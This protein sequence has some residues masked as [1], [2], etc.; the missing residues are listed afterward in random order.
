MSWTL[1]FTS[2]LFLKRNTK[3]LDVHVDLCLDFVDTRLAVQALSLDLLSFVLSS[4]QLVQMDMSNS[5]IP[6]PALESII[7]GCKL[8]EYLSLEGLQLSDA[9]IT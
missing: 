4:L 6:T 3:D 7:G 8:L 1:L 5:T 9:I 2:V